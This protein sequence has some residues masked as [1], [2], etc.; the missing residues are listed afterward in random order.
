LNQELEL[1]L[2]KFRLGVTRGRLRDVGRELGILGLVEV[3]PRIPVDELP[4]GEPY[5]KEPLIQFPRIEKKYVVVVGLITAGI[6]CAV[7]NNRL[8]K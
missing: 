5:R 8:K 1:S 2:L 4:F 6:I 3:Y 7:I